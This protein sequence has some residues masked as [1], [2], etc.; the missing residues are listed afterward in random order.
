MAADRKAPDFEKT[1]KLHV[2]MLFSKYS[3]SVPSDDLRVISDYCRYLADCV[4]YK[5]LRMEGDGR[6][7]PPL[8]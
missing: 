2:E 7:S 8:P 4:D 3:D 1:L 5:N 6:T